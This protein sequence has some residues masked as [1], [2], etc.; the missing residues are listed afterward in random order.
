MTTRTYWT[1][2][3]DKMADECNAAL[4]GKTIA[5][6]AF[7]GHRSANIAFTDGSSLDLTACGAEVDDLEFE[8]IE[9]AAGQPTGTLLQQEK[10]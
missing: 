1:G 3:S 7:T 5:K 2:L 4:V 8:V 10:K 6:V 9:P